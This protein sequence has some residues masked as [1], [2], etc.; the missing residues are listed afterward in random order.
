MFTF[1]RCLFGI[2]TCFSDVVFFSFPFLIVSKADGNTS[3]AERN[4]K[5][6]KSAVVEVTTLLEVSQA[7]MR[8]ISKDVESAS[9]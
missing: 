9:S 4:S 6:I 5:L 8:S 2:Q 7:S 3:D 1:L